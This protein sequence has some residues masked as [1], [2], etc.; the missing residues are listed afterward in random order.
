MHFVNRDIAY[1]AHVSPRGRC[2]YTHNIYIG[3]FIV[4][5]T[6]SDGCVISFWNPRPV[7]TAHS[8]IAVVA[9]LLSDECAS[10]SALD[11]HSIPRVGGGGGICRTILVNIAL[12]LDVETKAGRTAYACHNNVLR[13]RGCQLSSF[14]LPG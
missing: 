1:I 14:I 5:S 7:I 11:T 3:V 13:Y 4:S 12:S 10:S 2:L 6:S 8:Q 9:H